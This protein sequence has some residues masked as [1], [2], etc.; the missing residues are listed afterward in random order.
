MEAVGASVQG[1]EIV[2][3]LFI[4]PTMIVTGVAK[5]I[6]ASYPTSQLLFRELVKAGIL[7]VDK[8][9]KRNR[10]FHASEILK[11]VQQESGE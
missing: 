1:L 2:D 7:N 4:T 9:R 6:R 8:R 11:L 5:R 10:V 3:D